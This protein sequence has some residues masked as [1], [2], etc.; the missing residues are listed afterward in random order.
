M[1]PKEYKELLKAEQTIRKYKAEI[2]TEL[3]KLTSPKTCLKCGKKVE[4]MD[5]QEPFYHFYPHEGMWLGGGVFQMSCGYGSDHD[6][7]QFYGALCDDCITELHEKKIIETDSDLTEV[8]TEYL[9]KL[10]KGKIDI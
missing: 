8:K 9:K 10:E 3:I 1:T 5:P 2:N 4:V 6:N 7:T